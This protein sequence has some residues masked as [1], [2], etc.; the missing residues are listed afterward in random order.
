MRSMQKHF[1]R[2]T[3]HKLSMFWSRSL[4]Q[5][6]RHRPLRTNPDVTDRNQ[7]KKIDNMTSTLNDSKDKT[8]WEATL[9]SSIV[10]Y[11][12]KVLKLWNTWNGLGG[13]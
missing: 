6:Y 13:I 12:C 11:P 10:C 1:C 3:L 9:H 2:C 7:T 4:E 5:L 8:G